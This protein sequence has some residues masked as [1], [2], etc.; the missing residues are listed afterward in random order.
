VGDGLV[1]G[2]PGLIVASEA[3]SRGIQDQLAARL[4][5]V[6]RAIEVGD[7]FIVD[8]QQLLD[9]FMVNGE[10]DPNAFDVSVGGTIERILRGRSE[11]SL[12]RVYGEMVDIL[13]KNT[14]SQAAIRLEILWN[15]LASSHGFA[16]LCGYSMG[17]FFKHAEGLEEVRRHHTHVEPSDGK[18]VILEPQRRAK[19]A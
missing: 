1:A 4:I 19:T 16:L 6:R 3:H 7:L 14:Q 10:P 9:Q 17:N 8:A 12:V 5:D 11:R 18:V 15:K 2:Q 13:W